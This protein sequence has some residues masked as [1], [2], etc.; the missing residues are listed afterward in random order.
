MKHAKSLLTAFLVI[1][2]SMSFVRGASEQLNI[3]NPNGV[4]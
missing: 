2:L 1:A 3:S 4:A